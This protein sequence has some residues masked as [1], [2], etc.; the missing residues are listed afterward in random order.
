MRID[1]AAVDPER[2]AKFSEGLHCLGFWHTHPEAAPSVSDV[3][4]ELAQAH[5]SVADDEFSGLVFVIVG[6]APLPD[7]LGVWFH[8]SIAMLQAFHV[9]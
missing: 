7:G 9:R 3:D 8:N 1:T 5:A 4:L 6:S 2:A